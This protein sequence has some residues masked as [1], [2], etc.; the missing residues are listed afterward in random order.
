[1][2]KGV[3]LSMFRHVIPLAVLT[4]SDQSVKYIDLGSLTFQGRI[5]V[6][7]QGNDVRFLPMAKQAATKRADVASAQIEH[8]GTGTF[9]VP[10][11]GMAAGD[12]FKNGELL[13]ISYNSDAASF[14]AIVQEVNHASNKLVLRSHLTPTGPSPDLAD[15]DGIYSMAP[16]ATGTIGALLYAAED[17][18]LWYPQWARYLGFMEISE[19]EAKIQAFEVA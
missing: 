15:G 9:Y 2:Q 17:R 18:V 12:E 6:N 11:D 1:M 3:D 13:R 14:R 19:T 16:D 8:S 4:L 10:F 5:L 7:V